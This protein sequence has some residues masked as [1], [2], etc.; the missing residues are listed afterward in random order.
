MVMEAKMS[1]DAT[2]VGVR[3]VDGDFKLTLEPRDD[4]ACAGQ[5]TLRIESPFIDFHY[6]SKLIGCDLWG[7]DSML[8]L[9]DSIIADRIS[10]MEIR[11]VPHWYELVKAY[12]LKRGR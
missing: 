8:M 1:I 12:K 11:F 5:T 2:V 4:R 9:G 10:Y 6:L 7:N 3:L